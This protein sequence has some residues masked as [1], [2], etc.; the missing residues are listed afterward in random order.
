MTAVRTP[1]GRSGR[2]FLAQRLL[3]ARRAADLLERKRRVLLREQR[4][5]AQVQERTG[6]T[7][8]DTCS[9]AHRWSVR[10]LVLGDRGQVRRSVPGPYA[11]ADVSWQTRMGVSYPATTRTELP[12][13]PEGG[14]AAFPPAV[15]ACGD[16]L[17]AGVAHAAALTAYQRVS[18]ELDHTQRRL[19]AIR[20]RWIP[21]LEEQLRLVDV[22]LDQA[23]REELARLRWT[24]D[25]P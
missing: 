19:R 20:N 21:R 10:S 2:L 18:D 17:R 4:R 9:E 8:S 7:W 11:R 5:L 14:S 3:A 15:A 24:G 1:P 23:E 13:L 12:P 16:V 6:I 25:P 22:T